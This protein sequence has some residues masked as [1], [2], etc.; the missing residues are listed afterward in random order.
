M[1]K[2]ALAA[3]AAAAVALLA[4]GAAHPRGRPVTGALLGVVSDHSQPE[5]EWLVHVSR[6]NLR[7]MR[8]RRLPLGG[9][10]GYAWSFSPDWSALAL[11]LQDRLTDGD[12][13][14]QASLRFVDVSSLGVTHDLALGP[15][16]VW[17]AE[18]LSPDRLVAIVAHCCS[19]PVDLVVVDPAGQRVIHREP[20]AARSPTWSQRAGGRFV[21]LLVGEHT[22]GPAHLLVVDGRGAAREVALD[23]I[24]A[25]SE[26]FGPDTDP[27]V[28][29]V[30]PG[31]AV[32]PEGRRAF[33]V[34]PSGLVA[35]VDLASGSVSYH[36]PS[37]R[38]ALS[39]PLKRDEGATRVARVLPNGLLAVSGSDDRARHVPA[40]LRLVDPSTWTSRLIDRKADFVTLAGNLM[41]ATGTKSR[42]V[43]PQGSGLTAYTLAGKKRFRLFKGEEVFVEQVYG[44]RAFVNV[45]RVVQPS[46]L[47]VV[48]LRKGRVVGRRAY[49]KLP[50]LLAGASASG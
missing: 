10:G 7:P 41:L 21:A 33:V 6:R 43:L 22:I 46:P 39:A 24:D 37:A 29:Y 19:H 48:D 8:G 17:A 14:P 9:L 18:W 44:R 25:G 47:R 2:S 5:H 49:E 26:R 36:P 42:S 45:S 27:G 35:D 3:A 1:T 12:E 4:A 38:R 34:A 31:L 32:E 40:G 13:D 15:G 11:G 23:R 50:M 30:S 16:Y 20:L 28:D